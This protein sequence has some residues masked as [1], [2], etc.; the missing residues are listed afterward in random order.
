M[1]DPNDDF[2]KEIR[3]YPDDE[4]SLAVEQLKAERPQDYV[5]SSNV[6]RSRS[7]RPA[8]TEGILRDMRRHGGGGAGYTSGGTP[9]NPEQLRGEAQNRAF[10]RRAGQNKT[11]GQAQLDP[12]AYADAAAQLKEF[13]NP[14]QGA[15][16]GQHFDPPTEFED[17][18][19][20]A[21]NEAWNAAPH[22][23]ATMSERSIPHI[24]PY[25]P[26]PFTRKPKGDTSTSELDRQEKS[27]AWL[28]DPKNNKGRT[29][30]QQYESSPAEVNP[31]VAYS[32][33]L[34]NQKAYASAMVIKRR[35]EAEKNPLNKETSPTGTSANASYLDPRENR[36]NN[37][38]VV[39]AV[40][41]NSNPESHKAVDTL[42]QVKG[43]LDGVLNKIKDQLPP[44]VYDS[45]I[46]NLHSGGLTAQNTIPILRMF[47]Y[48]GKF[49]KP[50]AIAMDVGKNAYETYNTLN[51]NETLSM[52]EKASVGL[53]SAVGT[54]LD[55]L[56]T[57]DP[58]GLLNFLPYFKMEKGLLKAITNATGITKSGESMSKTLTDTMFNMYDEKTPEEEAE[59]ERD[60]LLMDKQNKTS[61]LN[62]QRQLRE[63]KSKLKVGGDPNNPLD[64][65]RLK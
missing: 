32:Q 26:D 13:Y 60:R 56:E 20:A 8:L 21:S 35:K 22:R 34:A 65:I 29:E 1:G 44:D 33:K 12:Y 3:D 55:I 53:A 28:A 2:Q 62:I 40:K 49:I 17:T 37:G 59:D 6:G 25:D 58:T 41:E 19:L 23:K 18:T 10:F 52:G 4:V 42:G 51:S 48:I 24:N 14:T 36:A 61:R 5:G 38:E 47:P 7:S 50:L 30:F 64:Y 11:Q 15:L 46:S 9:I 16:R 63:G 39:K 31:Q 54:G 27:L 43:Q 57:L 45:F